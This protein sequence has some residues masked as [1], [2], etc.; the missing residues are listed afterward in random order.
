M[1]YS[2]KILLTWLIVI[3]SDDNIGILLNKEAYFELFIWELYIKGIQIW[4]SILSKNLFVQ[5][6][7]K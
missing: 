4:W 1:D 6:T 2:N 3:I 5:F 7:Q